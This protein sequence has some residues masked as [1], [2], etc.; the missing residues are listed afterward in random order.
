[1]TE[2]TRIDVERRYDVAEAVSTIIPSFDHR[3]GDMILALVTEEDGRGRY[4]RISPELGAEFRALIFQ[5]IRE[6]AN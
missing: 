6:K 3:N 5:A 1:M 4:V 2:D